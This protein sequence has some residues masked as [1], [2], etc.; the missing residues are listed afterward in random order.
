MTNNEGETVE[1]TTEEVQKVEE[2]VEKHDE[3]TTE[4]KDTVDWKAK[5]DELKGQ[6]KRAETKLEK[7]KIDSKVEKK[8]E[9]K[10]G[11][12]DDA[13]RDFFDLKG[14]SDEEMEVFENIMKRTGM[15]HR[16]VIKDEYALAKVDSIRKTK[17][18]KD[19]TPGS[20]R[21]PGA[22]SSTD[23]DAWVVKVQNGG[24]LPK[25]FELKTQVLNRLVGKNDTSV[26]PWKRK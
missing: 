13:T 20:T 9:A 6:L 15:S 24:E 3:A 21:R 26:P 10:T 11:E 22:P 23:V 2:Q 25:D 16:E 1:E 7:L 19:A 12:L 8:L 4:E 17:A 14:Y 18:V 5:H